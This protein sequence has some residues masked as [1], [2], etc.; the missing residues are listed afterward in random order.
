MRLYARYESSAGRNRMQGSMSVG[1]V[2][3]FEPPTGISSARATTATGNVRE[4]PFAKTPTAPVAAARVPSDRN[5]LKPRRET[6]SSRSLVMGLP[7]ES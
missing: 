7:S 1:Y 4:Q 3:I 6:F 5:L 2:K